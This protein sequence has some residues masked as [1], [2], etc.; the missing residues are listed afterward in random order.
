MVEWDETQTHIRIHIWKQLKDTNSRS[1]CISISSIVPSSVHC[2]HIVPSMPGYNFISLNQHPLSSLLSTPSMT[3]RN[4]SAASVAKRNFVCVYFSAKFICE[5][6]YSSYYQRSANDQMEFMDFLF[7]W[8]SSTLHPQ[9]FRHSLFGSAVFDVKE[10]PRWSL[11]WTEIVSQRIHVY[12]K[13]W[14][15]PYGE[16]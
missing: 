13:N 12:T 11:E 3:I 2:H 7:W 1:S 16:N 4:N 6:T 14:R 5:S 15:M 9:L 8:S 10:H